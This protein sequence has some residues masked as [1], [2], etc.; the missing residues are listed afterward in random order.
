MK[1]P[2]PDNY[3]N[4][5][6]YLTDKCKW[7]E[8]QIQKANEQNKKLIEENREL[9]KVDADLLLDA[10]KEGFKSATEVLLAANEYAQKKSK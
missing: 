6:A 5:T 8:S 1:R 9:M 10:Y 2:N 3:S 7:L 4:R